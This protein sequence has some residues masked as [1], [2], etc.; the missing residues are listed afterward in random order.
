MPKSQQS[1][2]WSQYSPTQNN[3]HKRKYWKESKFWSHFYKMMFKKVILL[4]SFLNNIQLSIILT[5]AVFGSLS[6]ILRNLKINIVLPEVV[7]IE[8]VPNPILYIIWIIMHWL[9]NILGKNLVL[10]VPSKLFV[11]NLKKFKSSSG[12]FYF[13]WWKYFGKVNLMHCKPSM[14]YHDMFLIAGAPVWLNTVTYIFYGYRANTLW[15][16]HHTGSSPHFEWQHYLH[17]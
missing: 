6:A 3:V 14:T 11:L 13:Q 15:N 12:S 2:V 17:H 9:K 8:V 16:A 5:L 10:R 7:L 1:W 4:H